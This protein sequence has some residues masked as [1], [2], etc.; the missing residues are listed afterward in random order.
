MPSPQPDTPSGAPF[1]TAAE[2][3]SFRNRIGVLWGQHDVQAQLLADAIAAGNE[4]AA[5]LA[6]DQLNRVDGQIQH[7]RQA[8]DAFERRALAE[9][10][11]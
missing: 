11:A 7:E 6:R 10:R 5:E 4:R 8:R 3:A 2:R 1:D 9:G